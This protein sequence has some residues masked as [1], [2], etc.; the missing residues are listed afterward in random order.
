M[1][2]L[3][4][5]FDYRDGKL[6]HAVRK[7]RVQKGALAGWVCPS[8]NRRVVF[9][10]GRQMLASRA[11]WEWHYGPIPGGMEID[12]A[13]RDPMDDRIENLRLSDKFTN[14]AN[15]RVKSTNTS[16]FKGV[17][18]HKQKR[19]WRARIRINGTRINLGLFDSP[20]KAAAAYNAQAKAH[21]GEFAC[22]T[23]VK[24]WA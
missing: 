16:G 3:K 12:H 4:E 8:I 11:I 19:R 1:A 9:I 13:N 14:N 24:T 2:D 15:T 20:E 7:R 21:F 10:N 23:E 17:D 22:V 6:F 5:V 18:F